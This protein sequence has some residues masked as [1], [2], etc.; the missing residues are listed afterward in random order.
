MR[1]Q[2]GARL[3]A[4]SRNFFSA[5]LRARSEP[6][7]LIGEHRPPG[8]YR[9]APAALPVLTEVTTAEFFVVWA[10]GGRARSAKY[11][12]KPNKLAEGAPSASPK[13]SYVPA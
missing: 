10:P 2:L 13:V 5:A 6:P 11:A 8:A 1:G 7:P 9:R 12:P 4:R 3:I